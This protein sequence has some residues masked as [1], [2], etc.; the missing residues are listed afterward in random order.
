M[1]I[2]TYGVQCLEKN[3][4]IQEYYGN[5]HDLLQHTHECYPASWPI[6]VTDLCT[7]TL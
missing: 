6:I 7:N 5:T 1:G 3:K 4:H 2:S